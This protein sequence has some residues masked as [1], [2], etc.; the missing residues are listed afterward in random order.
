[1]TTLTLPALHRTST[2]VLNCPEERPTPILSD[3]QT[4]HSDKASASR[5]Y[6]V[7]LEGHHDIGVRNQK[8]QA[9][10]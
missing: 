3:V 6:D 5:V 2:S 7:H 1:M 10:P 8:L 4:V 9:C